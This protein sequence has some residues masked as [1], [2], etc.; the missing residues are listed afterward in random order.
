MQRA[1]DLYPPTNIANVPVILKHF[2]DTTTQP[3]PP[4]TPQYP[5][6]KNINIMQEEACEGYGGTGAQ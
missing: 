1:T 4:A 3:Q 5:V 2:E 6:P